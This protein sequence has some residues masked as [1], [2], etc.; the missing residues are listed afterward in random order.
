[1]LRARV[2]NTRARGTLD[3]IPARVGR[4]LVA[5][6]RRHAVPYV[7]GAKRVTSERKVSA[8]YAWASGASGTST[9][10]G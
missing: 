5:V 3:F 6:M 7:Y 4:V 2:L 10:T 8:A 1:M 9:G